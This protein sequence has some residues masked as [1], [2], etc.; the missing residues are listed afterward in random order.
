MSIQLES[1]LPVTSLIDH[2]IRRNLRF[3]VDDDSGDGQ[4]RMLPPR[5]AQRRRQGL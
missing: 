2:V 3:F 1:H 5:L 4:L